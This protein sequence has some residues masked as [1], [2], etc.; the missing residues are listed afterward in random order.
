MQLCFGVQLTKCIGVFMKSVPHRCTEITTTPAPQELKTQG[1]SNDDVLDG[2]I[3]ALLMCRSH[4][5]SLSGGFRWLMVTSGNREKRG[6][7]EWMIFSG[8]H[9]HMNHP[10]GTPRNKSQQIPRFPWCHNIT[11]SM[12]FI[13]KC[14]WCVEIKINFTNFFLLSL[15]CL[16]E[17]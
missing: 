8:C 12:T 3:H 17:K 15:R 4:G 7:R 9:G 2:S 14:W 5:E 16:L 1:A 6:R 13:D 10:L 11:V